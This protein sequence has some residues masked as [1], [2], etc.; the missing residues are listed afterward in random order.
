MKFTAVMLLISVFAVSSARAQSAAVKAAIDPAPQIGFGEAYEKIQKR[1][2]AAGN[3]ALNVEIASERKL[4]RVG[5]F[6]PSLSLVGSSN[7]QSGTFNQAAT[8][9][10]NVRSL[11]VNVGAN[12]FRSG[13]D[14]AALKGA[15]RDIDASE[16][17]LDDQRLKAEDDAATALLTLISRSR[18]REFI[19]QIVGLNTESLKI[20]RERFNHGLLPQQEVDKTQI[21]LDNAQARLINA[22]VALADAR[23]EVSARLGS[24]QNLNLEWPWR[25]QIASGPRPDASSFK[26]DFRPDYRS[27]LF[28]LEAEDW[29]KHAARA[30]LLPSLDFNAGAGSFDLSQ[31]RRDWSAGLTLTIPIFEKFVGWSQARIQSLTAQQA[32]INREL[33]ARTANAEIESL[34]VGY[35]A[36]RESAIARERTSKLTSRIYGDSLQRFRMGRTSANDLSVDQNRLLETQILEVQ[37]WTNAHLSLA[38]LC[39]SLGQ[40]VLANGSCREIRR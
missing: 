1:N 35:R 14:F 16:A 2:L 20:A 9:S 34:T 18:E 15:N 10:S 32:E 36:A 5:A 33:I 25:E 37:G 40:S 29:R 30:N 27:A 11:T 39:H 19:A 26:L 12:I 17:S 23:A 38:R 13:S 4:A 3:Q 31:D 6:T 22:D 21:D 8:T 7:Q 28:T 24:I